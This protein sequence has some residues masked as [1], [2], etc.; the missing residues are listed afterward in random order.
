MILFLMLVGARPLIAGDWSSGGGDPVIVQT[1]PF[2]NQRLLQD[3]L[4]L[5]E[6]KI[7]ETVFID[8][9][10]MAFK[11]E[12]KLLRQKN[13][14]F[15]IPDLFSVGLGRYPGDY[16]RLV[17]NGAMTEF[18]S[19]GPI[20]FSRQALDYDA[21]TLARVIAQEIPHHI[22]K[23]SYRDNEIFV[24][25]LGTYIIVGGEVP[26]SPISLVRV[27]HEEFSTIPS[28]ALQAVVNEAGKRQSDDFRWHEGPYFLSHQ[29]YR[30][31]GSF[32]L[33]NVEYIYESSQEFSKRTHAL[34]LKFDME[35]LSEM[36]SR[37]VFVPYTEGPSG[38][39]QAEQKILTDLFIQHLRRYPG[40]F[41]KLY[42]VEQVG[43]PSERP[44]TTCAI[45][46]EGPNQ[47][48]MLFQSVYR[49]EDDVHN[50]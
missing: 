6:T 7:S 34:S 45:G 14:F 20:Y 37:C 11:A 33:Y 32:G 30:Q 3:A 1:Y 36:V 40:I 41:K 48:V 29:G 25:I 47:H 46:V 19:G 2:P 26:D 39:T 9:F 8:E 43:V 49:H 17:S 31:L 22:F 28:Q 15:Y 5:L 35:I 42:Y 16:T 50:P 12:L 18:V 27:I 44:V 21:R 13:N 10:K 24:N 4:D 38:I 23:S